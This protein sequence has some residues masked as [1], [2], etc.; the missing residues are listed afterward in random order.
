SPDQPRDPIADAPRLLH[1]AGLIPAADQ[2]LAPLGLDDLAR[3]LR[4]RPG[5]RTQRIA[6]EI[7]DALGQVEARA[8]S[9]E[10]G[11][12]WSLRSAHEA[13]SQSNSPPRKLVASAQKK[14]GGAKVRRPLLARSPI[15]AQ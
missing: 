3:P 2:H 1:P 10:V 8:R 7:D 5:Q 13:P 11:H 4:R 12:G 9:A 15:W 6:V 14:A